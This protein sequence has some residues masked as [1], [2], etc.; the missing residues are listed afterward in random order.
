[1]INKA[2]VI[3]YR[4]ILLNTA[5]LTFLTFLTFL[6][7]NLV[8]KAY[9]NSRNYVTMPF[10]DAKPRRCY[11]PSAD[12]SMSTVSS[13]IVSMFSLWI[14]SAAMLMLTFAISLYAT[15]NLDTIPA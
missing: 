8:V 3:Y 13:E 9:I 14:S 10:N 6:G 7:K 1:M 4:I 11:A 12:I 15:F 5:F 2:V